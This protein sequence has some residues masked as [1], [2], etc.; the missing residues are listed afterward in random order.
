MEICFF[1]LFHRQMIKQERELLR[2]FHELSE[3]KNGLHNQIIANQKLV[4]SIVISLNNALEAKDPYT[5]GHSQRVSR[6]A[7]ATAKRMGL[8]SRE[9][10]Q[11]RLAGLFHDI[12]KIGIR[13]SILLKNGPLSQEEFEEIKM[14]P[15]YSVKILEPVDPFEKVLKSV[16]HH[17]ENWDGTGYPAGLKGE[18]IPLG[19][20]IIH[21]VDSFD[22]MTSSRCY[23]SPL[24]Q[25]A[26]IKELQEKSGQLYHPDVVKYFI[27][28][29]QACQK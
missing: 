22:A 7:A 15:I 11:I 12:G 3:T 6:L 14:H 1:S 29:Y 16:L 10:E 23:R 5:L 27:K 28:L 26:A 20:S 17:H 9:C 24:S 18:D 25:T 13:D 2:L 8:S 19:A 21:V 4:E